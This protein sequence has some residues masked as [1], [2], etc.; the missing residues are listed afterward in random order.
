MAPRKIDITIND[1]KVTVL[2][3]SYLIK[4]IIGAGIALPTLCHHKDLTPN[5]TCRLCMCEIELK[6][7]RR[8][9]TACNYPVREEMTVWTKSERVVK[10]RKVLAEMYLGRWPNVPV[11]QDVARRCGVT[12]GSAFASDLTDPNPKACILC[13]HCVKACEEFIQERI[14]DFAGRG[15][16]RHLTMPF[17][18]TDPHC[19]GCTSCAFVCPTGAI[20]VVEE[21]NHP[22]DVR[23]IQRHGMKVNAEMATLDKVQCRMREVGTANIVEVMD[24]Y[25]L[26]PV[27][28]YKFGSHP[29][30]Y[31]VDSKV[32]KER[33]FTQNSPDGC[34]FGC[35]MSCAKAVDGYELRTGPYKG[36]RVTVDGPEYET[37]G[38][39]TNM[40]CFDPDFIV[41][42]NFYCDTYGIDVISAGTGI[43]FVME[44]FEAGVITKA[45]TGGLDLSFGACDS[46]LEL[47]HQ[48]SRGE[49][50]GVEC[51]Q[52]I[53]WLKEKWIREGRGDAQFIRD[54]GMEVKGLEFSEYVSKESLAQQAGYSMA[55]KG[56]QHDEAW[57]I[58]MDMVNNQIPSFEDKA[59]A[60]Y[61]FP[62]WRTW[63][64]LHG[65]CKIV[66]NDVAP[67]DNK[68]Y[69]PQ[70][71]AKI[72]EHVDNYFKFY[73]GMTGEKLDEEK[74]LAQSA[75]VHN[76]QRLMSVMF[77]F[78][79]RE[80][81]VPP[82]RAIGPVTAE[83]YLS[84][85]ERYDGQLKSV[86]G[87]DPEKM[88]LDEKRAA[89]RTHREAQYQK[90]MDAAYARRGW[91]PDGVP[92]K[93]RLRELGIDLPELLALAAD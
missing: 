56:P 65:L 84:R 58:F 57:L 52:G 16:L 81:D 86:L 50:F 59:E 83:E 35:S 76:L 21:L 6:G 93:A 13:G 49:G 27:M 45:D 26:L 15:I 71:A 62:L 82:Y 73:E 51:G 74:M 33:Y 85:A 78:G 1:Q 42:F 39:C 80:D 44:C 29:E 19:I 48:M 36:Q 24:K 9:V 18:E 43:A 8:L 55:V 25:D 28:N 7:R 63:F 64:G 79:R 60:L 61:Y 30:T 90:V 41:E 22:V 32:L 2:E 75:R 31:K 68:K 67:A 14:L 23:L 70:Q 38:A 4:A 5:G 40:G 92:T 34:W 47:L 88:T 17:G 46:V 10:H 53:R 54:V 72:P 91:T 69:P 11:I 89:L 12:D 66:W 20:Q 77:G 37:V 87:L 3:D